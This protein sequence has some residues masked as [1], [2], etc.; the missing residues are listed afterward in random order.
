MRDV[1]FT[2]GSG[3]IP[4]VI[5]AAGGL[6]LMLA[7]G[8]DANH[9]PRAFTFPIGEAHLAVIRE[10]LPRHLL[11]WS[12]VLPLCEAAGAQGRLDENAARR[13]AGPGP[14]RP[15]R[16]RRRA[17]SAHPMGP[18]PARRPRRRHPST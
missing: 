18:E 8:A 15:A 4:T 6:K 10:D 12:A 13:A 5:R 16:R 17:L 1:V 2:R 11:L 3:W 7:A 9:E 14:A